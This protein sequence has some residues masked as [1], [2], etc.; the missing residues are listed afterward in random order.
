MKKVILLSAAIMALATA[1]TAATNAQEKPSDDE[2]VITVQKSYLDG[3]YTG[4]GWASNWFVTAHGGISAFIGK[5]VGHGDLFDRTTPMLH[6][7]IGKWVT[8]TVGL[9]LAFEGF[10]FKDQNTQQ[11]TIQNIHADLLYNLSYLF[12]EDLSHQPTWNVMPLAGIGVI[13]NSFYGKKPVALTLGVNVGYR[14]TDRLLISAEAA[15]TVT[16]Q[17][18][19]GIGNASRLGDNL[20]HASVGLS[21]TIGKSGWRQVVDPQPYILANDILNER[22]KTLHQEN[23]YLKSQRQNG[24]EVATDAC[25]QAPTYPKNNYRGLNELRMRMQSKNKG[26]SQ[27]DP[28]VQVDGP[29]A[30]AAMFAQL[31]TRYDFSNQDAITAYPICFFFNINSIKL[32][33]DNQALN[34]HEMAK[35]I[36]QFNLKAVVVGAA[37]AATGTDQLNRRLAK[38]RAQFITRQLINYG[39]PAADITTQSRGG[40]SDYDNLP[41]NRNCKVM[42]QRKKMPTNDL[43]TE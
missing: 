29:T 30:D 35:A 19:D 31:N 5:P 36:K 6:L 3:V 42:L 1:A 39:V 23:E 17:D 11:H 14:V 15:N 37:D 33:D 27:E 38:R 10:N 24:D 18:F 9:R 41:A 25:Q 28:F 16:W 7:N 12:K 34:I 40:I 43:L 22:V 32:T 13:H 2:Q 21:Y 8:P 26:N 20:L 4:N